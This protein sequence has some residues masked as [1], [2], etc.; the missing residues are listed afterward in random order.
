[1]IANRTQAY[2]VRFFRRSFSDYPQGCFISKDVALN[3][4][5]NIVG[6]IRSAPE[7]VSSTAHLIN[8]LK[9]DSLRRVD[10]RSSLEKEFCIRFPVDAAELL[11]VP[12][13]AEF[14][15]KHPKAR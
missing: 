1:M 6:G 15:S 3:R 11:T 12:A 5:L 10:L 13:I 8:D 4:V 7:T 9:F 2:S 14:V